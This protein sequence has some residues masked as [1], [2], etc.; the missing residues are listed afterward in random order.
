ILT[1]LDQTITDTDISNA[2]ASIKELRRQV[3][4][5]HEP[6]ATPNPAAGENLPKARDLLR[7]LRSMRIS[8]KRPSFR[9]CFPVMGS[10]GSGRT[11][12]IASLVGSTPNDSAEGPA[13]AT[14]QWCENHNS[15][16]LLLNQNSIKSLEQTILDGINQAAGLQWQTL[17]EFDRFLNGKSDG[18]EE[19]LQIRFCL[20]IDDL[21]RW[22][23]AR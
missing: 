12:F 17:D 2:E 20:A 4:A 13:D 23:Q 10:L 16:V 11:H 9:K 18:S 1:E 19:R 14:N 5:A 22:L 6:G 15:L 21:Q 8:I 7:E 3:D